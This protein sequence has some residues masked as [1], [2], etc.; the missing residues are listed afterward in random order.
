LL[1]VGPATDLSKPEAR[2]FRLKAKAL[3]LLSESHAAETAVKEVF[4]METIS[5]PVWTTPAVAV[6]PGTVGQPVQGGGAMCNVD[7]ELRI[8]SG[9]LGD[10]GR[11]SGG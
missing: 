7:L 10:W 3:H 5:S 4:D 8:K 11:V 1:T 2:S 9:V 6:Y